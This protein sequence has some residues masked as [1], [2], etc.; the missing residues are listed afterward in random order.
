MRDALLLSR[1]SWVRPG[2]SAQLDFVH[3]R[4]WALGSTSL[5]AMLAVSRASADYVQTSS[6]LLLPVGANVLARSD[7]GA[8]I[9]QASTN[10]VLQSAGYTGWSTSPGTGTLT[11]NAAIAADGTPTATEYT[12]GSGDV[13]YSAPVTVSASTTYTFSFYVKNI[14][15]TNLTYAAYDLTHSAFLV[16][17]TSYT[18]Q[19]NTSAWTRISFQLTTAVGQTSLRVYFV[20]ASSSSAQQALFWGAQLEAAAFATPYIPTTTGTVT[21]AA[22]NIDAQGPLLAA[23][24]ASS[25]YMIEA[26]LPTIPVPPGNGCS[27]GSLM[28]GTN[29]GNAC[30]MFINAGES[31]VRQLVNSGSAAQ[32][33]T[34][35]MPAAGLTSGVPFKAAMSY[36]PANFAFSVNGGAPATASTGVLPVGLSAFH[37]GRIPGSAGYLN[38]F[39]RQLTFFGSVPNVQNVSTLP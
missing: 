31:K 24:L 10:I 15:A 8:Q 21:R 26:V 13:Y 39:M 3:N 17:A 23:A 14:S 32:F 9:W 12:F 25:G 11:Q 36:A 37:I 5:A 7:Q 16:N 33:G 1:P 27:I 34:N 20:A 2:A 19:V 28:A 4:Y 38:G 29:A 18:S 6:G 30:Y 35:A 22:A